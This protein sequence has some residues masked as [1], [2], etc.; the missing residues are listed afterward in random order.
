MAKDIMFG[1]QR[2]FEYRNKPHRCLA[3]LLRQEKGNFKN[4]S[5]INTPAGEVAIHSKEKIKVFESFYKHLYNSAE[6]DGFSIECFLTKIEV[7]KITDYHR[8]GL[9]NPI[10][11]QE[12]DWAID[13]L[14]SGKAPGTDG[15]SSEFYKAFRDFLAPYIKKL[16]VYCTQL[17]KIPD[18]WKLAKP[19]LI[20]KEGKDPATPGAY[21]PISLPNVDYKILASILAECLNKIMNPYI[22]KRDL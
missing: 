3:N 15:L 11:A 22:V 18:T 21:R 6:P 4:P 2:A 14:K 19:A 13:N 10:T 7:P 9:N 12:I 8:Q 1:K 5:Q 20:L 16:F 17:D